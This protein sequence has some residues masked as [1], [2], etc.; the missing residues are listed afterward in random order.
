VRFHPHSYGDP[1]GRVFVWNDALYRGIRRDAAPLFRRLFAEGIIDRL[2]HEGLLVDSSLT[3]LRL[4]GFELVVCHRRIPFA[5]YPEE[6]C[7]AMLRDAGIV[8][9]ELLERL[10]S[11]GLTLKD[12]HPWNVLYDGGRPTY[13]D[14][15]SIAAMDERGWPA[16]DSFRRFCAYPLLLMSKGHDRVARRLMPEYEGV[17]PADVRALTRRS[18][19]LVSLATAGLDRASAIWRRLAGVDGPTPDARRREAVARLAR[20][21]RRRILAIPVDAGRPDSPASPREDDARGQRTTIAAILDRVLTDLRPASVL[22]AFSRES[23]AVLAAAAGR[24]VVCFDPDPA[25]VSRLYRQAR[26][27]GLRILPLVMDFTDPTPARGLAGHWAIP[28]MQR[29]PCDVVVALGLV[30][31]A[32][33]ERRLPF[34]L[35]LEA[36]GELS[37]RW[38]VVDFPMRDEVAARFDADAPWC[39]LE[40]FV[41]ALKHR[42]RSLTTLPADLDDRVVLLCEK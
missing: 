34:E 17:R 22:Q 7:G 2:V 28:A 39:K 19:R 16:Y 23:Y 27:A 5:S 26:D 33:L 12:G 13:V 20:R 35:V 15:T 41:T 36:L 6:W 42:F 32:A 21:L 31:Y 30:R 11:H 18:A 1:A 14:L 38:L 10:A 4:D 25:R 3:P 8:M 40:S 29:F 24:T 37:K 9:L